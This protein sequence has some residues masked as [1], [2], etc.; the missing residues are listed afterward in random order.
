MRGTKVHVR[1]EPAISR[2]A[3]GRLRE[4]LSENLRRRFVG[5]DAE[6]TVFTELLNR[7]GQAALLWV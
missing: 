2:Q 3:A 1:E 5:R 6:I 4:R 7:T